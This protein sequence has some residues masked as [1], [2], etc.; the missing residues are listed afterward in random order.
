MIGK[1]P[2]FPKRGPGEV[3]I[4]G[5]CDW[6]HVTR[7]QSQHFSIHSHWFIK[8]SAVTSFITSTSCCWTNITGVTYCTSGLFFSSLTHCH[9]AM[10]PYKQNPAVNCR[11]AFGLWSPLPKAEMEWTNQLKNLGSINAHTVYFFHCVIC[12]FK[13]IFFHQGKIQGQ[14]N[15]STLV[16]QRGVSQVMTHLHEY[17]HILP[18]TRICI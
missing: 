11:S 2:F 17:I 12:H 15:T 5:E 16:T 14:E 13:G 6:E 18:E 8:Q 9:I 10:L 1:I 3:Y 4:Q 7:L